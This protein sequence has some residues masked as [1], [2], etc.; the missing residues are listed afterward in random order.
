MYLCIR[1]MHPSVEPPH[2]LRLAVKAINDTTGS[3]GLVPSTLVFSMIPSLPV[4]TR[5]KITQDERFKALA[6]ARNVVVQTIS[7]RRLD[8]DLRKKLPVSTSYIGSPGQSVRV[9]RKS[10]RAWDGPFIVTKI[11]RKIVTVT[12]GNNTKTFNIC[13]VLPTVPSVKDHHMKGDLTKKDLRYHKAER[14]K[15]IRDEILGL[16]RRGV[17]RLVNKN[18]IQLNAIILDMKVILTIKNIGTQHERYKAHIVV[19]GHGDQEKP[20]LIH[21]AVP[22]HAY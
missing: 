4:A 8:D 21:S 1:S 18:E 16:E 7:E 9:Y 5:N 2:E 15:E 10:I 6:T 12:D 13:Q 14:K 19:L 22:V 11:D 3:N 20:L 17:F